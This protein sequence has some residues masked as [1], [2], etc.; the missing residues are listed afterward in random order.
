MTHRTLFHSMQGSTGVPDLQDPCRTT[1]TRQF[2]VTSPDNAIYW[3][4]IA[5]PYVEPI[6]S[7]AAAGVLAALIPIICFALTQLWQQSFTDFASAVL[8]L[9]YSMVTGTCF[10]VILKKTIGGL[11]PHFLGVC[12]PVIPEG[13]VG[14]GFQNVM[15]T[16]EEV[17]T[18]DAKEIRNALESFPSGHAEVAFAGFGY[19]AIY[20]F[21][22]LRITSLTR[23]RG[24]HWRLLLVIAPL[25]LA[26]YLASTLVLGY[27]HHAYDVF[28]GAFIGWFMAF[29]G[30]RTVF[31][32][33][34]DGRWN[35]VPYLKLP[36]REGRGTGVKQSMGS[37]E[38]AFDDGR[39]AT[40]GMLHAPQM[41]N[42]HVERSPV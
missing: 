2:P 31:M 11:R 33:I 24:S 14:V 26:T 36:P 19:L 22:H 13:L 5:H 38:T 16:A 25:L 8:G 1:F 23:R 30:Y 29:M 37:E 15:Y 9:A 27:H 10:Q 42:G 18:G 4:S 40:N 39:P 17:C 21:A 28:F 12:K 41:G 34:F 7:S 6:F 20:L 3:P 32:G 35:T